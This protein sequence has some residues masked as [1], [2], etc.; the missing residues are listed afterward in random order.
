[1]MIPAPNLDDRD[2]NQLM[3]Q[4]RATLV[5]TC[6]EWTDLSPSDPGMAL[7]EA[8]A[9]LTD[10]MI[11]RLNRLPE[12][13]YIE[14]LRLLGLRLA[15]P[16]AATVTL[17]F[18]RGQATEQPVEIPKGTR[19]TTS[20]IQGSSEPPVF[21]TAR[22]VTIPAGETQASVLAYHCEY[23]AA[24][25][26]ATSTGLPGAV[27]TVRRPPIIAPTGDDGDLIVAVE[28]RLEEL[29]E[30][31][32]AIQHNGK[33]YR[34]WREVDEF[35]AAGSGDLVYMADRAAGRIV[36]APAVQR[37]QPDN[38][39]Q[40]LPGALAGVPPAGREIRVWYRRG[41]GS[42]GN[43]AAGLLT[44]LKDPIAGITVTNPQAA[45]GGQAA[46]T[47]E[48]ALIRG[49]LEF[50]TLRRAATAGDFE[51]I[52][53][54]SS[55]AIARAYAFTRAAAWSFARPGS[56]EVLLVPSVDFSDQAAISVSPEA[57]QAH[58]VADARAQVQ[59]ALD[60]RK[61]LGTTCVV[62][63]AHYKK[64]AVH[65]R[66]VARREED[67]GAVKQRIL[68]RLQMT[69][70][71]L[72]T[73]FNPT[74]WGFGQALRVSHVYDIALAEPGVRWVDNV[75]F[76]VDDVPAENV[77][78]ITIDGNQENTWYA[79]SGSTLF[80]TLN[81]GD[82][83]EP[84]GRFSGEQVRR[85]CAHPGMAGWVAVAT[86]LPQNQGSRISISPDCGEN[87]LEE[88]WA[89]EFEALDMAWTIRDGAPLLLLATAK[90]L[91]E[92]KPQ[93]GA[94]PVQVLVDQT[95]QDRGFYAVVVATDVR[96]TV[97]V[98]V[99]AQAM[100]GVYLSRQG[101]GSE[102]F[103]LIGLSG[104][105]VRTLAVQYNGPRSFLWA[106]TAASGPADRGKGCF[107]WELTGPGDPP[108]G[109][110]AYNQ[111]WSGGSCHAI[112]FSDMTVLAA[113]F[114]SGIMRLDSTKAN[115]SWTA[116]TVQSGLPLRDPGR[117]YSVDALAINPASQIILAAGSQGIFRSTDT[118]AVF[119]PSSS[120]RF[121]DKVLLPRT[122]LFCS[123]EHD[124]TVVNEDETR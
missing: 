8:F 4:A 76:W 104:Q 66:V 67:V 3:E 78:A 24:E 40:D 26:V 45:T 2:F 121:E 73:R 38:R 98:A 114:R 46:E 58:Q 20:R 21:I 122:W 88:N 7:L 92:L 57:L 41:G 124:I 52:A 94:V 117:F 77:S 51:Q 28:A 102:T 25:L 72:P 75:E 115:A 108:D 106:G 110:R 107:S 44:V 81:D 65:A 118:G 18:T 60:Q 101:G 79:A 22:A 99:A 30:R 112:A 9:F 12:K 80:R 36:F 33:T 34:I 69:I 48:N 86:L 89:L 27:F 63:W 13:A 87:W 55:R 100:A 39:L 85:I 64:V 31:A 120:K 10:T 84:V 113:T 74:G 116:S 42:D 23:V 16:A 47:L 119:Q 37:L 43:V 103:R 6:P 1:M 111:G 5:K 50:R 123:G 56:V 96:G 15:P 95:R 11:Y 32:P 35:A 82:S 91:Y 90:G 17:V 105:D 53:L 83:W 93:P 70:C 97:S 71:P 29:I 49:P 54:A 68:D 59:Q 62:N 14:F 61:T 109:W 19:V